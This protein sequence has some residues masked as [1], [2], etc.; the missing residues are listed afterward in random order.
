MR[1]SHPRGLHTLQ[2][3]MAWNLSISTIRT[4]IAT[5]INTALA[6]T[7]SADRTYYPD[8]TA[9]QEAIDKQLSGADD[10][11]DFTVFFVLTPGINDNPTKYSTCDKYDAQMPV[12]IIY[13]KRYDDLVHRKGS[14]DL[15]DDGSEIIEQLLAVS[16]PWTGTIGKAITIT[17]L[18]TRFPEADDI[19]RAGYA[20]V[21]IGLLLTSELS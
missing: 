4:T 13:C 14:A 3:K 19:N 8:Q 12:E 2:R 6:I 10:Q 20:T 16:R 5:A 21:K 1:G 11:G 17:Q 15:L 9:L 18:T 7:D